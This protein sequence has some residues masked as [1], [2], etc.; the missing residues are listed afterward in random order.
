MKPPSRM[1]EIR[2]RLGLSLDDLSIRTGL[3]LAWLSR[4]ERGIVKI[5]RENQEKIAVGLNFPLEALFPE[6]KIES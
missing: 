2:F 6:G 4:A 5:N 3:D 1:R